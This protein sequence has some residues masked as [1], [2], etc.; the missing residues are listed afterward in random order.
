MVTGA[1]LTARPGEGTVP[2]LAMTIRAHDPRDGRGPWFEGWLF[3]AVALLLYSALGQKVFYKVDGP[4]LLYLLHEHQ[5]HGRPLQ[6]PW[7]LGYLPLLDLFRQGL[8][9]LG[10]Q[11]ALL[12]L[13]ELFSAFGMALSVLGFRQG[14][15]ALGVDRQEARGATLLLLCNPG[16]LLFAS[17]VEMHAPLMGAVGLA[18]WWFAGAV[19]RPSWWRMLGLGL[20]LHGAFLMHATN[21]FLPALLLPWFLALRWDAGSRRADLW[22]CG[23]AGLVHAAAFLV[24]PRL[25]PSFY[26]DYADLSHAFSREA[27]IGRPQS[28]DWMPTIFWQEWL[29]P[30][31]PLSVT[32]SLALFRRELRLEL[33]AFAIGFVPF[34]YLCTRQLVFE[35][36]YGAYMLP[37]L[38]PAARLSAAV[39]VTSRWLAPLWLLS[40]AGGVTHVYL[41]EAALWP[42]YQQYRDDLLAAADGKPMFV[43]IGARK[44]PEAPGVYHDELAMAYALLPPDT[45]LWVR[46]QAQ[47]P[48]ADY[49]PAQGAGTVA[50][51]KAEKCDQGIALLLTDGASAELRTPSAVFRG[52]K[53]TGQPAD[54]RYAGPLFFKAL[55]QGFTLR[56]A[57]SHAEPGSGPRVT[58]WRLLPK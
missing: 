8:A 43:L 23:L 58:V 55:Q 24:L 11:P 44:L 20:F 5:A 47:L 26:G 2:V 28:L 32:V 34:L 14:L 48:R 21:L 19:M 18:F 50:F 29:L 3:F 25:W 15:R 41:H 53:D 52:E 13:G 37:L 42:R 56:P 33:L 30:L 39:L 57:A 46:T 22:L 17:V 16:C 45:F 9:L 1:R 4:D 6:H 12:R 38:L 36:E 10:W 40:L 7:H 51:L 27:S 31:L 35:P 49:Q 54:D